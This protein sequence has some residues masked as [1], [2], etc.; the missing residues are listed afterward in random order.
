VIKLTIY[1]T[2][3]KLKLKHNACYVF[4]LLL[5]IRINFQ[6]IFLDR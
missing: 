6:L 2:D 4:G 5:V 1:G 3:D